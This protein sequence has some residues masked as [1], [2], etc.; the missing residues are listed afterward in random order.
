[1]PPRRVIG[2]DAGGTKLLGGVVDDQLVVHHRVRRTWR[3][4][5]RAE[6]LEIMIGAVEEIRA[7]APDIE[8]VGFGI[9]SLVDHVRG[10]SVWSNHLP[11]DDVPFRDLMS[12]RLGL[13]VH[14]D[15]DTNAAILAEHRR[16]AARGT[17]HAVMLALGT[18]IGGGLI[19]GGALHRGAHG[20]A[21]ELGHMTVDLHGE[22]C[23]GDCP[24]QGCFETLVSGRAIGVAAARV[25]REQPRSALGELVEAGR[26]IGGGL[27]T[28]LAHDGDEQARAVL[29]GVGQRLGI[30]IAG[31]VNALDPEVVV[32]G[33]GAVAAGD[34]LLDPARAALAERAL[35]PGGE[36]P[37]IVPAHFGDESGMLGAALLALEDGVAWP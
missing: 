16:G 35:P 12:E 34:L 30:G 27:V 7:A 31:I 19:I 14:V 20:F 24:G 11:I 3:G 6:T 28:E 13:P 4:A 2:I 29:A 18:G 21:G 32:I 33:G 22:D 25:G 37:P 17:A 1:M 15:N 9:P 26:R 5:D 10:V 36:P 23:P 8:A